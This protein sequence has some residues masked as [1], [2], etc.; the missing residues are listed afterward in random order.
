MLTDER[1]TET[2][3]LLA[4]NNKHELVDE[5]S[6][7]SP[8][9]ET[10]RRCIA[11]G[12]VR[13]KSDL[14]RFVLSPDGVVTP[15]VAEKLPGRGLWVTASTDALGEAIKRNKFAR[16]ARQ[17]AQIPDNLANRVIELLTRRCIE[18]LSLARRAGQA[19]AGFEKCSAALKSGDAAVY[20]AALDRADD[21]A[22]K[23]E[24][25]AAGTQRAHVLTRDELGQAFGRSQTVH[26]VIKQGGLSEAFLR[27]ALKLAGFRSV[28][29]PAGGSTGGAEGSRNE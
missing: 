24:R 26:V 18:Y 11:T 16:A 21:G 2:E 25:G 12:D 28:D 20:T 27:N 1:H 9:A 17:K 22:A 7:G 4:E 5:A 29:T 3:A 19:V 13:P 14:I 8:V 15:D 10:M 23:L 6:T